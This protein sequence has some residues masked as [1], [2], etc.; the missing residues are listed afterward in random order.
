MS[1]KPSWRPFER[2]ISHWL[3]IC[4]LYSSIILTENW[5]RNKCGRDRTRCTSNRENRRGLWSEIRF[6][7]AATHRRIQGMD[8]KHP[9]PR[10]KPK[11]RPTVL[12]IYFWKLWKMC[13]PFLP[14]H[15]SALLSVSPSHEIWI[16]WPEVA[17]V[18]MEKLPLRTFSYTMKAKTNGSS[19]SVSAC[20][21]Q[22]E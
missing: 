10:F 1:R 7:R 4:L 11:W 13:V 2:R 9:I 21:W 19:F 22:A 8:Y 14:L 17:G 3:S 15:H 6:R 5:V 12:Y 18:N 16:K 20:D